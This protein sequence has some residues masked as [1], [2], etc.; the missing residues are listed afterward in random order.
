MQTTFSRRIEGGSRGPLAISAPAEL[1]ALR[2]TGGLPDLETELAAGS[3]RWDPRRVLPRPRPDPA[4]TPPFRRPGGL[5]GVRGS[6]AATPPPRPGRSRRP[7]RSWRQGS[8]PRPRGPLRATPGGGEGKVSAVGRDPGARVRTDPALEKGK[9]FTK[10]TTMMFIQPE[11]RSQENL[12]EIQLCLKKNRSFHSLPNEVQLQLCPTAI[13]QE[14]EAESMLLR[15]GRVSLECCLILA[16]HLKVMSSSTSMNKNT[17]SEILSEFEEGDFIGEICLLPN[18]SRPASILCKKGVKL[19][20]ISQD[21]CCRIIA[22][23][24]YE[25]MSVRSCVRKT[26]SSTLENPHAILPLRG[27]LDV[28]GR[29]LETATVSLRTSFSAARKKRLDTKKAPLQTT[30]LGILELI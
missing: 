30:P 21:G 4:P 8:R 1:R 28:T 3:K 11:R 7:R 12:R 23:M 9:D 6:T 26:G 19:L 2:R 14:L 22:Q 18:T 15:Q 29:S 27:P 16:G 20:V 17:N 25:E 5:S 13:Y 24:N 10:L